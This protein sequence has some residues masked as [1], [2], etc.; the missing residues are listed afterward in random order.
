MVASGQHILLWFENQME[1]YAFVVTTT[2]VFIKRIV[3]ILISFIK[4]FVKIDYKGTYQQIQ[5]GDYFE[6]L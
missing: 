5:I 6:L 3:R 1:I 4:Y 2:L